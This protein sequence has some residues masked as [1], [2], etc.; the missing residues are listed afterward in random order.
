MFD[1]KLSGS[2]LGFQPLYLQIADSIKQ[3]IVKQHWLPGEALPSEFR[4][5][6]KFN[7]S[8]GTVRKALNLLTDDKIVIRRQGVCIR[9]YLARR[10]IQVFSVTSRQ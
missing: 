6:E 10:L 7:V 3:L 9:A 8:Q 1:Q 5:A 4:L 2:S